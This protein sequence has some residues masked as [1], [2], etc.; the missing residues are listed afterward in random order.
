MPKWLIKLRTYLK[1]ND[2]DAA[3]YREKVVRRPTDD[4]N[5]VTL[6]P[7]IDLREESQR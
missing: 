3:R 4:N 5:V 7:G 1:R 6:A 2:L